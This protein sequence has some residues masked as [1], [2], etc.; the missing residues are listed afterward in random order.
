MALFC[1]YIALPSLCSSS[2]SSFSSSSPVSQRR[3]GVLLYPKG[4]V[5]FFPSHCAQVL[6]SLSE[7]SS[8]RQTVKQTGDGFQ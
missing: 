8:D 4:C 2:F 3:P 6:L 7:A 5:F 1:L